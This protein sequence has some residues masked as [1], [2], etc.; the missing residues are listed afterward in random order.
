MSAMSMCPCSVCYEILSL[1]SYPIPS[2][3][4]QLPPP[5]L[6]I[7]LPWLQTLQTEAAEHQLLVTDTPPGIRV[8]IKDFTWEILT[9]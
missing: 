9:F 6:L 8:V 7:P 2:F 3:L 5:R 4:N 1:L